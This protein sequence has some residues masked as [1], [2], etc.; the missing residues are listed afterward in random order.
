MRR[1]VNSS[2]TLTTKVT[3]RPGCICRVTVAHSVA[4]LLLAG[5]FASYNKQ[6]LAYVLRSL[7]QQQGQGQ[8]QG[9]EAGRGQA[10]ALDG[11]LRYSGSGSSGNSE[12]KLQCF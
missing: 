9:G 12:G 7:Q 8:S 6:R 2:T 4:F 1:R 11:S 5:S 3:A 10:L